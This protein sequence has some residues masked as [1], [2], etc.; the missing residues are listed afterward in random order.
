[1]HLSIEL[2]YALVRTISTVIFAL[3]VGFGNAR[4]AEPPQ[5]S[6]DAIPNSKITDQGVG[7]Y[8]DLAQ[9][10]YIQGKYDLCLQE[11]AIVHR[12]TASYGN[13]RELEAFCLKGL[14]LIT[15]AAFKPSQ[16]P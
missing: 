11:L 16:S 8:F 15:G 10:A 1:M 14:A 4:A 13:S 12:T 5:S 7:V 2:R 6:D 9:T 3:F